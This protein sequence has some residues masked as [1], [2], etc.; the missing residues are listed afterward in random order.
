MLTPL[1]VANWKMNH[2]I[3]EAAEFIQ[4]LENAEIS[5]DREFVVCPPFTSLHLFKNIPH[6]AQN[7]HW[8][9]SGA[10][11]GEVSA[12]ML[13]ELGCT[14]V[15]IGHSERRQHFGETDDIVAK[16][17]ATALAHG[18][19]PIVCV[20]SVDEVTPALVGKEIVIAYEP[21]WAIGTGKAATPE[22]AQDIHSQIRKRVGDTVRILYGGSVS[23]ENASSL[24]A[25]PDVNGLLVGGASLDVNIFL[26]IIQS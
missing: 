26:K 4:F 12:A 23:A 25:Q 14:Y 11:T 21:V 19:T 5:S 20:R 7:M 3:T 1:L 18:L 13:K 22:H 10:F 24:M 15:I 2:G 16:K 9:E 17:V 8:E 6:G